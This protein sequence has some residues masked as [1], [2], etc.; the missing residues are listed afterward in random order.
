[1]SPPTPF[2][3]EI[4]RPADD[5][6]QELVGG[7]LRAAGVP[8][9]TIPRVQIN[10]RRLGTT[11]EFATAI[12][13][14]P[15]P[16]LAYLQQGCGFARVAGQ[17]ITLERAA[18]HVTP[19]SALGNL[20]GMQSF[21][22]LQGP[23]AD[24]QAGAPDS[25]LDEIR[26]SLPPRES[27][28]DP[29]ALSQ[30]LSGCSLARHL[31]LAPAE[32]EVLVGDPV[33][34]VTGAV[35]SQRNDYEQP[36]PAIRFRRRYDSRRSDRCSSLG[37]G[38]SHELDQQ[39]YLEE[40]GRVVFRD[41]DGREKEFS[42]S[43]LLNRVSRPG[44][45]LKDV[46]G[47]Y[48][49]RCVAAL[50]WELSDGTTVR[51]FAPAAGASEAERERGTSRLVR[52]AEPRR[53]TVTECSYEDGRL[54]EVRVDG[55]PV[56]RFEHGSDG[57]L[58]RLFSVSGAG[59][60]MQTKYEYSMAGDLVAVADA[61]GS[62]R[63]YEYVDHLLVRE[64]NREGGS[65]Y[66][67]YE[68][69]GPRARCTRTWGD[70]GYM[71]RSLEYDPQGGVTVVT[72]S[73]E[74]QT[75][76]RYN[77]AGLVTRVD[78]PRG[79]RRKYRYD[80]SL[81]LIGIDHPDGTTESADYDLNGNLVR[82]TERD[83]STYS[84][85]YGP[86]GRLV[87]ATDPQRGRWG[88]TFD[89]RGRLRRVED[90][91]G[92]TT[93]FD[94]DERG[95]MCR[96]TEP[97]GNQLF[98]GMNAQGQIV[99]IPW[100]G[101]GRV[102]YA[103]DERGRLSA[104]RDSDDRR[105]RWHYDAQGRLT[106]RDG[107]TTRT[108]WEHGPEGR[109]TKVQHGRDA[110]IVER[111][112][113]GLV[114]G[115]DVDGRRTRYAM[116]TEGRLLR[117]WADD[118]DVLRLER[119]EHGEVEAWESAEFG[120]CEV[121]RQPLSP[122]ITGLTLPD[123]TVSIEWNEQGRIGGLRFADG[124]TCSYDYRPDGLLLEA[125]HEH[126]TCRFE[127]EPRGALRSQQWGDVTIGDLHPDHRGR[128]CGLRMGEVQVSYLRS[129]QGTIEDV[130]VSTGAEIEAG[131]ELRERAEAA[132]VAAPTPRK[133]R[134]FDP[135]WRAMSSVGAKHQVWDEG[136]CIVLDQQPRVHHPDD[137]HLMFL[138]GAQGTVQ[139]VADDAPADQPD[140]PA[141]IDRVHRAAF[142]AISDA[143]TAKDALPTPT[144]L[145]SEVLGYRAWNLEVRPVPGTAPWNPDQWEPRVDSPR[146]DIG[147]LDPP[148]LLAALGSP[149]P[150][151]P[152]AI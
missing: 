27:Y 133:A 109:L 88:Y 96:V 57:L 61:T 95:G 122:R 104:A 141:L 53:S 77:G 58:R 143:E 67:A 142:P 82:R 87:E 72:D 84:M 121:Q 13:A 47:R 26:Q 151:P 125:S 28:D 23:P 81:R 92:H 71:A 25:M 49:L 110:T 34:V 55:K 40:G 5:A 70:G 137:G 116:D 130:A 15:T 75:A 68:G 35:I 11:A 8:P 136:R 12:P 149:L 98:I 135:L 128:R 36:V 30:M 62:T 59:E 138:V 140:S 31:D 76:Y 43:H 45:T 21:V 3:A 2:I 113:H 146:P 48:R 106:D 86:D 6:A 60:L 78:G 93:R 51:Y 65:F 117:V 24:E 19:T 119:T 127:R 101:H 20:G 54:A 17:A 152:L 10:G 37:H 103:Y 123:Q 44:D 41:G 83:G 147:R 89:E 52:V 102:A 22:R 120:R 14:S 114:R 50:Q 9:L 150:R 63:R 18:A 139:P 112:V 118:A 66:Y 1:M 108:H 148:T 91:S 144:T 38:W 107:F 90:P 64:T 56:L 85:K 94:Y 105:S 129:R 79:E 134:A 97:T 73:L 7:L 145:L 99:E 80:A 126:I 29:S 39:I 33:N 16:G 115:I 131:T 124:P 46:T 74:Q 69:L 100:P 32:H 42:T 4:G 111:D 132:T